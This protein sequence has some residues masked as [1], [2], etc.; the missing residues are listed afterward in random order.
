M[1]SHL[2][3]SNNPFPYPHPP[4][5][6]PTIGP[7]PYLQTIPCLAS[8]LFPPPL[9]L[10]PPCCSLV[11]SAASRPCP[12]L[13][14]HSLS[15]TLDTSTQTHTH[16]LYLSSSPSI[17]IVI[18]AV[19]ILLAF[20]TSCPFPRRGRVDR[21]RQWSSRV[22]PNN[23]T[24][25]TWPQ[26][27]APPGPNVCAPAPRPRLLRPQ[28]D[29]LRPFQS[30]AAPRAVPAPGPELQQHLLIKAFLLA[31]AQTPPLSP[32]PRV[33]TAIPSSPLSTTPSSNT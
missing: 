19:V 2:S 14:S 31:P 32:V 33:Q 12:C 25:L 21:L 27:A 4:S 15:L 3:A 1:D 26:T 5:S 30:S 13:P 16:T 11:V 9:I 29:A 17:S 8:S 6:P 22:H 28:L 20:C 7:F 18:V 23:S 24:L 10:I